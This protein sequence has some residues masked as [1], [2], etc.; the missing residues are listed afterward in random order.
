MHGEHAGAQFVLRLRLCAI[1]CAEHVGHQHD[2]ILAGDGARLA[3]G[4][5]ADAFPVGL[6][7]DDRPLAG[8][9]VVIDDHAL[10]LPAVDLDTAT[11]FSAIARS[12]FLA[13]I[14]QP[15]IRG[16]N[17]GMPRHENKAIAE[18]RDRM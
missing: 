10:E 14:Y 16:R 5:G 17:G 4:V 18:F 12:L 6:H 9:A 13:D 11:F 15:K 2:I 1:A 8:H 3:D 7:E